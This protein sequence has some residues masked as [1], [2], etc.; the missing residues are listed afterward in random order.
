MKAVMRAMRSGS[1]IVSSVRAGLTGLAVLAGMLLVMPGCQ[2][3]SVLDLAMPDDAAQLGGGAARGDGGANDGAWVFDGCNDRGPNG[4]TTLVDCSTPPGDQPQPAPAPEQPGDADG[5][6]VAD[7]RDNCVSIANADQ[8]D[9]DGDGI[10]DACEGSSPAPAPGPQPGPNP[11]PGSALKVVTVGDSLTEGLGDADG[12]GYPGTLLDR[13]QS[14]RPGS[15]VV[16][17]GKS[18]W[19]SGELINGTDTEPGQL[20]R[21]V[22]EAPDVACVWIGGNDLWRLYEWLPADTTA[23]DEAANLAEYTAN[24]ETI[25]SRLT[26]AGATVFIGLC[27]DQSLRPVRNDRATLPNTTA[28]EFAQMSAQVNRY[29]DVI[30]TIAQRYRATVVDFYNT[31]IFTDEATLDYDGIHANSAGYDVIA[32]LWL[33]AIENV[34]E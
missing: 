23:A 19:T 4:E 10:G 14:G 18:G 7:D 17:L 21:A 15:T 2:G 12:R 31:T 22:A 20:N 28:A 29:N 8:A 16:N 6:G 32:D 34:L 27:D 13:L 30:R 1:G 33:A 9:A 25:V 11:A 26:A 3:E 5:D 24:I